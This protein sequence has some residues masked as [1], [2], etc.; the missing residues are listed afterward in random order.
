MVYGEIEH[1]LNQ[2]DDWDLITKSDD[3]RVNSQYSEPDICDKINQRINVKKLKTN[4][5]EPSDLYINLG[6]DLKIVEP[7]NFTNTICFTKLAKMLNLT[8]NNNKS[9]CK[10]FA[11]Q[12]KLGEIKL[13]EDYQIVYLNKQTKKFKI[14]SLTQLPYDC[15]TVN[16]S[17]CIQTKIPNFLIDR[18][19]NE[20]F[21]LV[22]QIFL[23]Y[24]NKR[25]LNPAKEWGSILNG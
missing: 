7:E 19:E 23:E 14:C 24:I 22:Y 12:K 5:R 17:N 21:N 1:I 2:Y 10:S 3:G 25:I 13:I 20:K 9:I 15:I 16:P 4:N 11:K 18:D 6:E 8:G